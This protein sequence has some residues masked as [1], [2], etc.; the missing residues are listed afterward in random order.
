MN[1]KDSAVLKALAELGLKKEPQLTPDQEELLKQALDPEE[2][3]LA[4]VEKLFTK[5]DD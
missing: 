3:F 4:D 5:V 2:Q 1:S